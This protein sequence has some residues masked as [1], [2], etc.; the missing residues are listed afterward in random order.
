MKRRYAGW[1]LAALW[2]A[3]GF[4]APVRQLVNL[5]SQI[6]MYEGEQATLPLGWLSVSSADEDCAAVT[7]TQAERLGN[8]AQIESVQSGSSTLTC[9]IFGVPLRRVSVQVRSE[10]ELLLGGDCVGVGLYLR[11]VL[12]VG[13]AEVEQADGTWISPA[14][15]AGL[16]PGDSVEAINGTP[17]ENALMFMELLAKNSENDL[18]L[19]VLRGKKRMALKVNLACDSAGAWRLGAWVRDSTAGV[20][21]LTYLD[22]QKQTYG[23]LG[24]SIN[25]PDTGSLLNVGQG[26][27]VYARVLDIVRGQ[28]GTPGELQIGR[29]H[30]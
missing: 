1:I 21:T 11:G 7:Q 30:V 5:P 23:A 15:Q 6:V 20:G 27:V 3:L 17:V 24:H 13:L 28:V 12:V 9:S 16:Q 29:A 10:R 14:A 18:E 4:A 26:N 19:T 2:C 22:T 8:T 25:D